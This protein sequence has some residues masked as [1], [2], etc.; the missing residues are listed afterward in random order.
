MQVLARL[1]STSAALFIFDIEQLWLQMNALQLHFL[2]H[3]KFLHFER[4]RVYIQM[5]KIKLEHFL[6]LLIL[7]LIKKSFFI[8]I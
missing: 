6:V 5:I 7:I 3:A 1:K 4:S 2:F 8:L